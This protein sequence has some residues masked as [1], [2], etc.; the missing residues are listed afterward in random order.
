MRVPPPMHAEVVLWHLI[1][2]TEYVL[3][4]GIIFCLRLLH[5][6]GLYWPIAIMKS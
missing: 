5:R 1:L 6:F 4:I 3:V 2:V